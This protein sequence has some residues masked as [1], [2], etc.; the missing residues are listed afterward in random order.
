MILSIS[1]LQDQQSIQHIQQKCT[2]LM[3][4]ENTEGLTTFR[5]QKIYNKRKVEKRNKWNLTLSFSS[6]VEQNI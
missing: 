4:R 5:K 6:S 1:Q 2:E 3:L